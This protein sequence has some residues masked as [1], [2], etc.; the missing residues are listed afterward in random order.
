ML[1][2][3]W[4]TDFHGNCFEAFVDISVFYVSGFNMVRINVL[5]DALNSICNAERRG[6]RQVLLRPSSKVIIKFLTVMMKHGKSIG[7]LCDSCVGL[8]WS[9]SN[10]QKN[11]YRKHVSWYAAAMWE[12][13]NSKI[14]WLVKNI[15]QLSKKPFFSLIWQ[16]HSMS[17]GFVFTLTHKTD[18]F[19]N[20]FIYKPISVISSRLF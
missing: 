5:S 12:R 9:Y 20:T 16:V 10:P 18:L 11:I 2:R 1:S 6:K 8:F 14:V 17:P 3:A 7:S 4:K 15:H 13:F 19:I